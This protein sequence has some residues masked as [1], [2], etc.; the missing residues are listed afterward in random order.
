MNNILLYIMP[1]DYNNYPPNWKTEIRPAVLERA[2]N[3]CEVEGCGLPNYAIIHRY[4]KGISDWEL[5]PEGMES[6]AWSIANIKSTKIILT[7]AHLDHYTTNNDL[8]NLKAMCQRCHLR[9]DKEHHSKNSRATKNK[10][11]GLIELDFNQTNDDDNDVLFD[12]CAN[13][14]VPYD[15]IDHEYQICHHCGFNRNK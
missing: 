14:G 3:C 6:E 7:I 10:K 9:Y 4:G 15:E 13:C 8:S 11:K 5:W 1:C 2:N 12:D